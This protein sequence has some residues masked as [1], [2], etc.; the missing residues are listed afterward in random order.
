MKR[1]RDESP[2]FIETQIPSKLETRWRGS[3]TRISI[4]LH[5][6]VC[7]PASPSSPETEGF[8]CPG[9]F[10]V[11][12][13]V[14]WLFCRPDFDCWDKTTPL[15]PQ[16]QCITQIRRISYQN[17][18]SPSSCCC[19]WWDSRTIIRIFHGGGLPRPSSMGFPNRNI[20]GKMPD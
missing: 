20:Q 15:P 16:Q 8:G 2:F 3:D 6:T 17:S 10:F 9:Q 19:R 5:C 14:R 12:W 7:L 18:S 11:E 13:L 1:F 4:L